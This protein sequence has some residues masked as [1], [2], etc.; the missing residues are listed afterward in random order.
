MNRGFLLAALLLA[1]IALPFGLSEFWIFIAIE[2]LVFALY[3]MSFN[4]L[5]GYGGML[6]FG[7]AAFFGVGGY[8]VAILAKHAGL[9]LSLSFI[10]APF[11]AGAMAAIIGFFS[12]RRIGIYFAML[13]FAFQML[14]YTVAL[15][16]TGLTG[17]DDGITG[18]K[19][20][21]LLAQPIN[22]YWFALVIVVLALGFIHRVVNSPFGMALQAI[23]GNARRVEYVGVNVR[24]HQFATFVLAGS[25]AGLA[26]A[27]FAFSSGNVFPG[28]LNWTAS[29]TPIVMAVLGG[30]R[31]FIGPVVGA[32]VYVMLEVVISGKTEYWPLV[33]GTII[34]VLVL[35]MPEGIMGITSRTRDGKP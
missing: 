31:T 5:L 33:M 8:A 27:V 17:G 14:L 11:I 22:Y 12:V 1:A 30:F 7:H 32:V 35:L 3:A 2:V 20:T 21:G 6:S 29:A 34:V 15:K 28:W 13:T 23:R 4:L 25:I 10:A 19:A 16:A 26:G 18:L 9:P 24:A